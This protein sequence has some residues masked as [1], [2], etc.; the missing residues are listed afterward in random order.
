MPTFG[1]IAVAS[2][3]ATALGLGAVQVSGADNGLQPLTGENFLVQ[4]A[5][6]TLDCDPARVSTVTFSASGVATGPYPG[7]FTVQGTVTIAPQTLAGPRPGTVA[8]PLLSLTETFTVNSPVGTV[9]GVKRLPHN[10]PSETSQG[11]CQHVTDFA[12]GSVVG[13]QGTVVDIFSQPRYGAHITT[14]DRRY[15]DRG[16]AQF[17]LSELDLNGTCAGV[18]CHFRQ[19]GF[20]QGFTSSRPT[21]DDNANDMDDELDAALGN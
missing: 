10:L 7:P 6:L 17:S 3:M 14:P 2:L 21:R 12:V 8:G 18:A 15:H 20:S 13:G 1:R 16:D 4:D 9:T 5:T 19:A 11:S